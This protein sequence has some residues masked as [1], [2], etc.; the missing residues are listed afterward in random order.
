[1][2][3]GS[4]TGRQQAV[5][6]ENHADVLRDGIRTHQDDVV[7][8][9]L[10]TQ[11]L[12]LVLVERCQAIH[13]PTS[14]AHSVTQLAHLLGR[15]HKGDLLFLR[16]EVLVANLQDMEVLGLVGLKGELHLLRAVAQI[17][18]KL[19]GDGKNLLVDVG[20]QGLHRGAFQS[21]RLAL[22]FAYR[23]GLDQ[24]AH[25]VLTLAAHREVTIQVYPG[26]L[27]VRVLR[28]HHA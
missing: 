26:P 27:T 28:E 18:G 19:D 11:C 14:D 21:G 12:D 17:L 9:M 20:Q 22:G 2:G 15:R 25:D 5:A 10:L 13:G 1:M 24:T 3:C 16:L 6:V 8:R 7:F 23:Q 4:A